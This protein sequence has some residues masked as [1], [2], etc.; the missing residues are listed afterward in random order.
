MPP[1]VIPRLG[2][3]E[4]IVAFKVVTTGAWPEEYRAQL[5][6]LG[7]SRPPPHLFHEIR[8]MRRRREAGDPDWADG[9]RKPRPPL[10]EE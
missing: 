9:T 2:L 8:V 7:I 4:Q 10:P 6:A 5:R 3:T 1:S